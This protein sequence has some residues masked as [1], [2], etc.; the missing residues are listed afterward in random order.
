[1]TSPNLRKRVETQLDV[2]YNLACYISG[3]LD[4]RDVEALTAAR[5]TLL[6]N[7]SLIEDL[8]K[9]LERDTRGRK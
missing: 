7:H 5:D 6:K 3:L 2:T 4:G 1:M 8:S 9:A